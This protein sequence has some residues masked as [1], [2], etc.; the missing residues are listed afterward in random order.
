MLPK[1]SGEV[2]E[3]Y[4]L[5]YESI[6]EIYS[7]KGELVQDSIGEFI[8]MTRFNKGVYFIKFEG[9]TFKYEKTT[10][11]PKLKKPELPMKLIYDPSK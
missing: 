1:D 3:I 4:D 7:V 5:P 2:K 10:E 8:D 9:K 11:K 6:Y